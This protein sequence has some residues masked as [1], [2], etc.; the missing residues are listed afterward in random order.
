M[1]VYVK[2]VNRDTSEHYIWKEICDGWHLIKNEELS[3]I[4]EKMPSNTAEDMHYH[5]QAK[6]FFY[7]LSGQAI[8]R[9]AEREEELSAGDGIEIEPLEAHQMLNRSGKDVEFMVISIPKSHG[10]KVLV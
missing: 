3:I 10:D 8:M 2:K 1:G 5:R 6:Q 7:I 9:F 4:E